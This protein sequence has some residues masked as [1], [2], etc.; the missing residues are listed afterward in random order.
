MADAFYRFEEDR[1]ITFLVWL[2]RL[3]TISRL[4]D[5]R[6]KGT[7][8]VTGSQKPKYIV[9]FGENISSSSICMLVSKSEVEICK[10]G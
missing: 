4:P 3:R 1:I 7:V 9:H 5:V 8:T 2:L 10:N 6:A